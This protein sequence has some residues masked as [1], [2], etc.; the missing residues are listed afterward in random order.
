MFGDNTMSDEAK[1]NYSHLAK[2][3][4]AATPGSQA[5]SKAAAVAD[6]W[7]AVYPKTTETAFFMTAERTA[8]EHRTQQAN[9]KAF[10]AMYP[11]SA[12]AYKKARG[13]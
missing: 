13:L 11:R 5:G 1:L 9:M 10:E 2:A 7:K 6:Q 3:Y 8:Q 12:A 4:D